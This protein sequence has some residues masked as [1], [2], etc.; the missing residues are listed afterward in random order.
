MLIQENRNLRKQLFNLAIYDDLTGL[1]NFR[2]FT[3]AIEREISRSKRYGHPLTILLMDIDDFKKIND[4]YGHE[5]GNEVLKC[6][7]ETILESVRDSDYA[8]R[9]GGE[10]FVLILPQTPPEEGFMVA[11]RIRE[12]ISRHQFD[13]GNVTV[14]VGVATNHE[15]SGR[16]GLLKR[17]D[18]AMYAAKKNGKNRVEINSG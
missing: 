14:S 11:E 5:K 12:N 13:F 8:A 2:F 7:A 1:Y 6:L 9:Y 18:M 4:T 10:E 16:E 17:A 3:Q 15:S